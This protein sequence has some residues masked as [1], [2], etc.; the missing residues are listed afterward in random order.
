MSV[1]SNMASTGR[2]A[3]CFDARWLTCNVSEHLRAT[4]Q[5]VNKPQDDDMETEED[6]HVSS[7]SISYT[8]HVVRVYN[9]DYDVKDSY[10]LQSPPGPPQH[11]EQGPP[12]QEPQ[13]QKVVS[14]LPVVR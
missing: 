11:G 8:S 12:P 5:D 10:C 3:R 13:Q 4:F 9:F 14:H 1:F 6:S 7:V 2:R